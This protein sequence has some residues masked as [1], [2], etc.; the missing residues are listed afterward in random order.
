MTEGGTANGMDEDH[1]PH[2]ALAPE[3]S[4]TAVSHK[5]PAHLNLRQA[6]HLGGATNALHVL[7]CLPSVAIGIMLKKF[8]AQ[9]EGRE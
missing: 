7:C 3:L 1:R 8:M 4:L 5:P 2:T 6:V 9:G